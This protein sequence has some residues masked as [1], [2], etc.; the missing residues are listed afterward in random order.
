MIHA[1]TANLIL[2]QNDSE[3]ERSR[4]EQKW[5]R[6]CVLVTSVSCLPRL[7]CLVKVTHLNDW[8]HCI[9]EQSYENISSLCSRVSVHSCEA[10]W[11]SVVSAYRCTFP[12]LCLHPLLFLRGLVKCCELR[13]NFFIFFSLLSCNLISD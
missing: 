2:M 7:H 8:C 1:N 6:C 13:F 11:Y 9:S 4:E 5:L 12:L 10:F 3:L